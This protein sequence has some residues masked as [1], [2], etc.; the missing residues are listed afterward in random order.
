MA[1]LP[2]P[3]EGAR[4]R[5]IP[6]VPSPGGISATVAALRSAGFAQARAERAAASLCAGHA[7]A[8]EVRGRGGHLL[9]GALLERADPAAGHPLAATL[10]LAWCPGV[11]GRLA[12]AAAAE[13][14]LQLGDYAFETCRLHTLVIDHG[15]PL[16]VARRPLL[17]AEWPAI[18]ASIHSRLAPPPR[19]A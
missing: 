11:P 13:G 19:Q 16:P 17:A 14:L 3:L 2:R 10:S 12:R 8:W 6:I 18:R 5:L 15:L 7:C 4:I 1:P 9:A